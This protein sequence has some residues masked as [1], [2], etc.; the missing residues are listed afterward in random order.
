[1][2]NPRRERE[3]RGGVFSGPRERGRKRGLPPALDGRRW[4]RG[5]AE[6]GGG[7]LA[8]RGEEERREVK[9]ESGEERN[10]RRERE[11]EG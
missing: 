5:G 4:A 1:M 3:R 11:S 10:E 8:G 9:R 7:V 6:E 2:S